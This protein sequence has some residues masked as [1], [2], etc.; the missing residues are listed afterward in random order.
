MEIDLRRCFGLDQLYINDLVKE[1]CG[2]EQIV[3]PIDSDLGCDLR[4]LN[5]ALMFF[6]SPCRDALFISGPSGC[7]KTTFIHQI[8]A[9]LNWGVE[10]ITLSA[11]SEIQDL[12]GRPTIRRG[13]LTFDYG[14]LSRAMYFGEILILNEIDLMMPGELAALND[15]LEGRSLTIAANLGEVIRPHR[16]YRVVAT[17][18]TKGSGDNQGFYSG[19]KRLN[20]A[21]LDRWRFLDFTY[22]TKA[23]EKLLLQ[24]KFPQLK[25]DLAEKLAKLARELRRAGEQGADAE[26]GM[27]APQLPAPFSTRSLLRIA[28]LCTQSERVSVQMACDMGFGSRLPEEAR[29]YVK[30]LAND[31]FGH[32]EIFVRPSAAANPANNA[33]TPAAAGKETDPQDLSR[34]LPDGE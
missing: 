2:K 3:P 19:V 24:R 26:D 18:N 20:Q 4:C 10:Q 6:A 13:S 8:A 27:L 34:P 1:P 31:I 22:P 33:S 30:R 12:I 28:E 16:D 5:E 9:R 32:D 21:F 11:K 14:P 29:E 7:G 25:A 17:A 15:V 23:V